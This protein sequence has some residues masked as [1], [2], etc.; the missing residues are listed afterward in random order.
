M[1]TQAF[2][3]AIQ[4]WFSKTFKTPT[5]VQ[6]Q[7]WDSI[8]Q[9]Q[10]TLLAAPTGSGKTLAAFLTAIDNLIK[11]GLVSKLLNQTQVL[12]ISPLKALSNDIQ[13]NLQQPI[14]GTAFS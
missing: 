4:N 10:H 8:V 1:S 9:G 5:D 2:Y 14:Q 3:P 7:A 13:L 6:N 12:Y 11:D